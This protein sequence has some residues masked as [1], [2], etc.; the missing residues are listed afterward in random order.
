MICI[1]FFFFSE[2]EFRMVKRSCGV[3]VEEEMNTI[4]T[5]KVLGVLKPMK[6]GKV[7][8]DRMKLQGT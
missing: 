7:G 1:I 5:R 4:K 2:F 6:S 3:S 8:N